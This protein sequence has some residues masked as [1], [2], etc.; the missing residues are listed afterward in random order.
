MTRPQDLLT[1]VKGIAR[2]Q[3]EEQYLTPEERDRII[4][5]YSP[6][7][8]FLRQADVL[9]ARQPGTGQWLL[10]HHLFKTWKSGVTKTIWCRGMRKCIRSYSD[11]VLRS[12]S[13]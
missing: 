4:E 7:N 9:S 10:Q 1:S 5:W 12:S 3:L 6:I 11:Y 13:E 8:F 2:N